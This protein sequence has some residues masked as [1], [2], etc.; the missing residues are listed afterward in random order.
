MAT[1]TATHQLTSHL[2]LSERFVHRRAGYGRDY[3]QCVGYAVDPI[4]DIFRMTEE[5]ARAEIAAGTGERAQMNEDRMN[6][7]TTLENIEVILNADSTLNETDRNV[8]LEDY[9]SRYF[10]GIRYVYDGYQ[11]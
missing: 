8:L 10:D 2:V 7:P 4:Y 1:A 6:T 3:G 11:D 9:Y 5:E